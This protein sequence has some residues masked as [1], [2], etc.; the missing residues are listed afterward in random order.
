MLTPAH[1]AQPIDM[2]MVREFLKRNPLLLRSNLSYRF[3][4]QA[5]F[6]LSSL[7]THLSILAGRAT[8]LDQQD[9]YHIPAGKM[10]TVPMGRLRK[11][12]NIALLE[13]H[14]LVCLNDLAGLLE[15]MPDARGLLDDHFGI[16]RDADGAATRKVA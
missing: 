14:R 2:R 8:L 4:D 7:A 16:D 12:L 10:R 3:R 13:R 11:R 6:T 1:C 5:Q 15:R 9:W